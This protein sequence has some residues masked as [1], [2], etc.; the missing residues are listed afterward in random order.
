[1]NTR[2]VNAAAGVIAAAMEQ[3]KSI[4]A[5]LAI[6]LDSARLL[7]SPETAAEFEKLLRWH[8]EDGETITKLMARIERRR[9]RL[10]KAE[11]DL[12]EMR[13]LLS[14]T[15]EPR[16]IPAEVEIHERVAPAVEWLLGRVA[17]LE[18]RLAESDRPVDEDPIAYALTPAAEDLRA[19]EDV[20]PQV[21]RLR[22]LL[23]GQ[24]QQTGGAQ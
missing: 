23:A 2:A 24:R 7:Q 20:T 14:P 17:E 22:A 8:R 4:P 21:Q 15:G 18:A 12:L 16:R 10:V 1:M 5:S 9:A 19:E 3:G 13:G 6:A 11:A